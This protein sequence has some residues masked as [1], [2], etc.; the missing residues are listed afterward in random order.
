MPRSSVILTLGGRERKERE[1]SL[2]FIMHKVW[3]PPC[4]PPASWESWRAG[5]CTLGWREVQRQSLQE[6]QASPR[7]QSP[8][9]LAV[10]RMEADES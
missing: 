10:A 8:R 1:R 9:N 3:T 7:L 4:L 6:T 2:G 5:P